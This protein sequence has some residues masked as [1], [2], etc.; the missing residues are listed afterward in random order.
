MPKKDTLL[1][2]P[3]DIQYSDFIALLAAWALGFLTIIQVILTY[4]KI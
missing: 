4:S 1:I 2:L 3:L